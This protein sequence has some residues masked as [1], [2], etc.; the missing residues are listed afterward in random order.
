MKI[1]TSAFSVLSSTR[2]VQCC[3]IEQLNF[4][5]DCHFGISSGDQPIEFVEFV[6]DGNFAVWAD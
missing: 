2:D 4:G 1:C 6:L 5:H 3:N